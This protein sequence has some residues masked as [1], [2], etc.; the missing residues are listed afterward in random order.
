MLKIKCMKKT[1]HLC[2][3]AGNGILFR[4]KED[5]IRGINC[6]CLAAYL[7]NSSLLAY[8]FMS[9]HVHICIRTESLKSFI[10]KFRYPYTRYFNAKYMKEGTL[11]EKRFFCLEINGLHHLLTAIAYILRNPMHHGVA[12]TPLGYKY[13]SIRALFRKDLGW[14]DR[15]DILPDK[16]EYRHI[17][18]HHSLPQHFKMDSDGMILP[19]CSID[20]SDVEH[21]F[22]TA[23][24]LI[25]Y[26]NR[27]SGE[28]WAK[29]QTQDPTAQPPISLKDIEKGIRYQDTRTMLSNEHGRSSYN[30]MTDLE[31]CREI[32]DEILPHWG[33]RSIY[34]LSHT[35]KLDIKLFLIE[36]YH[37]QSA[38]IDRCLE[39]KL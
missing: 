13:S 11:G 12:G 6:L 39:L 38:Q 9:N 15:I 34:E 29:E 20:V 16:H 24:T 36:K 28:K 2:W 3:S 22:S 25:Y 14:E 32:D 19:E 17:P 33:K 1:Y 18:W 27:L 8:A 21:Q 37:F 10:K 31:L 23:R 26:L 4:S 35:E 7:T 5:F 30:S